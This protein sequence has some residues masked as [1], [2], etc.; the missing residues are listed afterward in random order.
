M[1]ILCCCSFQYLGIHITCNLVCLICQALLLAIADINNVKLIEN[2]HESW[3]LLR[4]WMYI[5]TRNSPYQA[6]FLGHVRTEIVSMLVLKSFHIMIFVLDIS[7][8]FVKSFVPYYFNYFRTT[9]AVFWKKRVK[10]EENSL[11]L[12]ID[13]KKPSFLTI[14]T[15]SLEKNK[16]VEKE[17]FSFVEISASV[18]NWIFLPY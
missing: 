4:F 7:A 12:L 5:T 9:L 2:S 11:S 1:V 10:E 8:T 15:Y 16:S 13:G 14:S 3:Y 18:R 17:K 6:L